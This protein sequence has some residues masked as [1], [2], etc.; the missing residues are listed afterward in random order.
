MGLKLASKAADM[1]RTK[2]LGSIYANNRKRGVVS[3]DETEQE[4]TNNLTEDPS[5]GHQLKI[6]GNGVTGEGPLTRCEGILF[7]LHCS[8]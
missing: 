2:K 7:P 8:R 4:E 1:S 5:N 3:D 6:H